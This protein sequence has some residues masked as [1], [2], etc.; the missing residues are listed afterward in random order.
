MLGDVQNYVQNFLE[1]RQ[2]SVRGLVWGTA[3]VLYRVSSSRNVGFLPW[4]TKPRKC[5]VFALPGD[6]QN[7]VQNFLGCASGFRWRS[8][9]GARLEFC[10]EFRTTTSASFLPFLVIYMCNTFLEAR[11]G[12]VRGPVLGSGWSF[13]Q[14]FTSRVFALPGDV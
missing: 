6:V 5:R 13:V 4:C 11:Q 3:G 12:S 8:I 14:S 1:A 2:G 7:Y 10:T 9:L